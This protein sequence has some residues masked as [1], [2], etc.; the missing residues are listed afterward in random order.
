MTNTC[1]NVGEKLKQ[2]RED[3]GIDLD[4]LS[5][6]VCISKKF[7]V[8]I[9]EDIKSDLPENA[10]V[11]GFI[12]TISSYVGMDRD[13]AVQSYKNA[14]VYEASIVE[15][16]A[17]TNGK[18]VH[19]IV[20]TIT[21]ISTDDNNNDNVDAK[22]ETNNNTN[23]NIDYE[24]GEN[25][26]ETKYIEIGGKKFNRAT[27]IPVSIIIFFILL[28]VISSI[29]EEKPSQ[30]SDTQEDVIVIKEEKQKNTEEVEK[31]VQKKNIDVKKEIF[32]LS[33]KYKIIDT[34]T[35]KPTNNETI[36]IFSTSNNDIIIFKND[37]LQEKLNINNEKSF[38]TKNNKD[39]VLISSD[40]ENLVF[41]FNG[42]VYPRQIDKSKMKDDIIT[43]KTSEILK[44]L[45][46]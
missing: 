36:E 12:R 4:A 28:G 40:F 13:E 41:L 3:K 14:L 23:D 34:K 43:M 25:V 45:K 21:E 17:N 9:E 15:E 20:E 46:K 16:N 11:L 24:D 10:Y 31:E 35:F 39:V 44:V 22:V 6:D 29:F 27:F 42:S 1:K 30:S 19:K 2:A 18:T 7:I 37:I 32:G 5:K 8:A 26:E 33:Q 38:S